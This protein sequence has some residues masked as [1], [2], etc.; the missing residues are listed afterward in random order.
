[1]PR[2]NRRIREPVAH[3]AVQRLEKELRVA[4]ESYAT[5]RRVQRLEQ[6]L[7]QGRADT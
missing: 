4:W 2:K 5:Q 6:Q 7:R 1:M 3:S